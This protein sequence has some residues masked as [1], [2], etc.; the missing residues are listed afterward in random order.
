MLK[1]KSVYISSIRASKPGEC[2]AVHILG[3]SWRNICSFPPDSQGINNPAELKNQ[4]TILLGGK[5][6]PPCNVKYSSTWT[7]SS[8]H[9]SDSTREG[10]HLVLRAPALQRPVS[11]TWC[12]SLGQSRCGEEEMK[13]TKGQQICRCHTLLEYLCCQQAFDCSI[14]LG[15]SCFGR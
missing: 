6:R 12:I 5:E 2:K 14:H 15:D 4:L 13:E 9:H 10:T 3:I 8:I 11:L 7:L 1:K